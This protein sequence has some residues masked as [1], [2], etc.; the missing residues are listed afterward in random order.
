MSFHIH[1]S[2]PSIVPAHKYFYY[3]SQV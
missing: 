2:V 1:F 3:M